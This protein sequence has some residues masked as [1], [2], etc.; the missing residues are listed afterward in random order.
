MNNILT[1]LYNL[2]LERKTN[3]EAGS[4]TAYLF[5][6]GT[7]KILKKC[8]EECMEVAIATKNCDKPEIVNEVSDLIYH[9]L[10]LLA[11]ENVP[12]DLV[13]QELQK[14]AEKTSN[15]KTIKVVDKNS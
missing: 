13:L 2:I 6:K 5:E 9:L 15:L 14:R 11:N 12:L 8:G 4:Y 7:D 10:V 1:E 3:A